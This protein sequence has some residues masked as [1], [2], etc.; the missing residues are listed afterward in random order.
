MMSEIEDHACSRDSL[1]SLFPFDSMLI[2]EPHRPLR[3]WES[4][5]LQQV[6]LTPRAMAD[7]ICLSNVSVPDP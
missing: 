7:S 4:V 2:I 1:V 6:F 3:S 5:V